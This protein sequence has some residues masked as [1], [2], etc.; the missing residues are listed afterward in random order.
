LD[1]ELYIKERKNEEIILKEIQI[2]KSKK[3]ISEK[4]PPC[5]NI[6]YRTLSYLEN[7]N[8]MLKNNKKYIMPHEDTF[9]NKRNNMIEY[10][11]NDELIS[12]KNKYYKKKK[13][14]KEIIHLNELFKNDD[15]IFIIN[16]LFES[17]FEKII[18]KFR[19]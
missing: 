18:F 13:S 4:F 3:K 17:C 19:K 1:E 14:E 11:F 8:Y 10:K 12:F 9:Q 6:L 2:F 7:N 5:T 16:K 15:D